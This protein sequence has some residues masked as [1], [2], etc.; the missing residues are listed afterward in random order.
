MNFDAGTVQRHRLDLDLE[1]VKHPQFL[2][3]AIDRAGLRQAVEDIH[4]SFDDTRHPCCVTGSQQRSARGDYIVAE[5]KYS[6]W[7][8]SRRVKWYIGGVL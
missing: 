5:F 3:N 4:A 7:G 2:E 8:I 6:L 1:Q